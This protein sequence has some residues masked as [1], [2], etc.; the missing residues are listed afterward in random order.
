[1]THHLHMPREVIHPPN[2]PLK[3]VLSSLF[4]RRIQIR[5]MEGMQLVCDV[6]GTLA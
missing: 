4:Y 3:K 6:F 2:N 5:L 1:M